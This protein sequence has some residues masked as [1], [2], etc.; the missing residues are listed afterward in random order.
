MTYAIIGVEREQV[1]KRF[2]PI[3]KLCS[4]LAV[5]IDNNRP[6]YIQTWFIHAGTGSVRALTPHRIQFSN[7]S[8]DTCHVQELA[9][10]ASS[11]SIPCFS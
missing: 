1:I 8:I 7:N 3:K 4:Q 9:I 2:S 6:H 5:C 10:I 11:C